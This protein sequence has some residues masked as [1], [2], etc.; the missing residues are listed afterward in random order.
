MIIGKLFPD[1]RMLGIEQNINMF[2]TIAVWLMQ[3]QYTGRKLIG[4]KNCRKGRTLTAADTGANGGLLR[5]KESSCGII[6]SARY[7]GD[8]AL[9]DLMSRANGLIAIILFLPRF[10]EIIMMIPICKQLADH[11]IRRKPG[12]RIY[13]ENM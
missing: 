2:Q 7:A 12:E 6:M 10:G 11:A 5:E 1:I 8:C 3:L 4:R 13:V 9:K